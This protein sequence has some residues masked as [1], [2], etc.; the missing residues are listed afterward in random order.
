MFNETVREELNVMIRHAK[1]TIAVSA[2]LVS[3]VSV[4][5]WLAFADPPAA[6][7]KSS[8]TLEDIAWLA[9]HW[10]SEDPSDYTDEHWAKP[11][12]GSM[13]G[14][15]RLHA[16]ASRA[17]YEILLIEEKDGALVYSM[18]HFGPGLKH[19]DKEPLVF[20]VKAGERAQELYFDCRESDRPTR[21]IYQLE[22]PDRLQITLEKRKDGRKTR[23]VFHM[24]R[25]SN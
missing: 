18:E 4:S 6:S 22:S 11:S 14:M 24:R 25:N 3:V 9:G 8:L 10:H 13:V 21:L 19:H 7:N 20:D 17:T 12:G 23:H 15:C 5:S 2:A 16:D 1:K